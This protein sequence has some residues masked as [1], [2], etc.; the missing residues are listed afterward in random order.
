MRLLRPWSGLLPRG[1]SRGTGS[2]RRR[3]CEHIGCWGSSGQ[4]HMS[5]GLAA[6][7]GLRI[8]DPNGFPWI[9]MSWLLRCC[10]CPCFTFDPT[11][12]LSIF[13]LTWSHQYAGDEA[14]QGQVRSNKRQ[15][16]YTAPVQ[17]WK[18][19]QI[20]RIALFLRRQLLVKN[21]KFSD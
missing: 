8:S 4:W 21:Y 7:M 1:R 14:S 17:F 9:K 12:C 16:P 3:E 10:P 18:M 2:R 5:A 15:V 6:M 13:H 20:L 11:C 19:K